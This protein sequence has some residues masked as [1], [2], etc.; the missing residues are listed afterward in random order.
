MKD[1]FLN[2]FPPFWFFMKKYNRKATLTEEHLRVKEFA[3]HLKGSCSITLMQSLDK[4]ELTSHD[5]PQAL[6]DADAVFYIV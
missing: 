1:L 6:V 4:G 3:A 5:K 2:E